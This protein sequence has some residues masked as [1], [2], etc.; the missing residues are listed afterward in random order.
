MNIK[1]TGDVN[2]KQK[3]CKSTRKTNLCFW[4]TYEYSKSGNRK[5]IRVKI[6][7]Y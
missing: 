5:L 6:F 4:S 2:V 3:Y 7:S 1:L